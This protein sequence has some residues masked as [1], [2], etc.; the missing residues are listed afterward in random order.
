MVAVLLVVLLVLLYKAKIW[1]V[2]ALVRLPLKSFIL[3]LL[4]IFMS[5]V[6]EKANF[7]GFHGQVGEEL[8]EFGAY[9]MMYVL[10]RDMGGRLRK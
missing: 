4:F 5:W 7:T 6:G 10:M 2:L 9:M 1:R 8:A 3:L